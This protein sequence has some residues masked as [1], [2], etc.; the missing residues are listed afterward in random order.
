MLFRPPAVCPALTGTSVL[1]SKGG[2]SGKKGT[3]HC[4][5]NCMDGMWLMMPASPGM[6]WASLSRTGCVGFLTRLGRYGD[7]EMC[8]VCPQSTVHIHT[9]RAAEASQCVAGCLAELSPRDMRQARI[10]VSTQGGRLLLPALLYLPLRARTSPLV[11]CQKNV[12]CRGRSR[13]PHVHPW[14]SMFAVPERVWLAAGAGREWNSASAPLECGE[15]ERLFADD[16]IPQLI[17]HQPIELLPQALRG[18]RARM[19]H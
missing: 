7:I 10:R 11:G 12:P 4:G 8:N 9:Y 6:Q 3:R 19:R 2:S 16:G 14:P 17:G 15:S 18:K 1:Y 13:R 5:Q